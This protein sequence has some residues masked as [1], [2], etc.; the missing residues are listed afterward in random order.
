MGKLGFDAWQDQNQ[1]DNRR[2]NCCKHLE[3]NDPGAIIESQFGEEYLQ[4]PKDRK[5]QNIKDWRG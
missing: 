1:Q 3:G 5:H 2:H 4:R